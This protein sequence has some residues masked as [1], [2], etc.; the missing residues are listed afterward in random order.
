MMTK[1]LI[2]AIRDDVNAALADVARALELTHAN[3]SYH[4]RV[5]HDIGELVVES[6]EKIRGVPESILRSRGRHD[7]GQLAD[8]SADGNDC[9]PAFAHGP[10]AG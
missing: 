5:L 2:R 8:G 4:L 1:D 10:Q 3:A 9:R 6:E 7:G